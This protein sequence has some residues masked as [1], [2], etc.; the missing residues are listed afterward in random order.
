MNPTPRRPDTLPRSLLEAIEFLRESS[1]FRAK[2]G[3]VFVDYILAIKAFE[4]NRF[5]AEVTDWEHRE[6]FWLF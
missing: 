3:D 5:M 2:L 4:V 1:M 6:Y